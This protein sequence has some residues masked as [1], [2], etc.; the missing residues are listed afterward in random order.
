M[1]KALLKQISV[2]LEL[3]VLV[4]IDFLAIFALYSLALLVRIN[5][6]PHFHKLYQDTLPTK[7][8]TFFF[9]FLFIY[10][11]IFIFEGIYTKRI[12][13][14]REY[15]RIIKGSTLAILI[16]F[17][18]V[19]IGKL[20]PDVSRTVLILGYVFVII[21][22]PLI[23]LFLKPVIL[24]LLGLKKRIYLVAS[25]EM[26]PSI[27]RAI[28]NEPYLSFEIVGEH[29]FHEGST[30]IDQE[31]VK[32][33]QNGI[34]QTKATTLVVGLNGPLRINITGFIKSFSGHNIDILIIPDLYGIP[35]LGIEMDYF[36]N[37]Q[38]MIINIKNR[39]KN[40]FYRAI[41]RIFDLVIG[42]ILLII[43]LPLM[44][45]IAILIKTDSDGSVIYRHRRI[46]YK[47]KQFDCLKF[48]SMVEGADKMLK[49]IIE[50]NP[51]MKEEWDRFKKLPNDP[52]VTRIGR[53]LRKTSLDELPQLI[54]VIKG[55]MS[56]V[57]PRPVLYEELQ[58]FKEGS[59]YYLE[60][61]PGITGLWQISG[62][63][64]ID[65]QKRV[66][67]ESWY[68]KN[69]SLWLDITVIIRTI[70]VVFTKAGAY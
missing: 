45:V 46:G 18:I 15:E 48:R 69:Y 61:K 34:S 70:K 13:F 62:R 54:N 33:I 42:S 37:E 60:V 50:E 30:S 32:D 51:K 44:F 64:D 26:M 40:P 24:K 7:F 53:L 2:F 31:S 49:K 63:S 41:K 10:I 22:L 59:D 38:L 14:W 11:V 36:F 6:L 35:L 12:P 56:L 28:E 58:L 21:F 20:S 29:L 8:S 23:K 5:I 4:I 27:R 55:D 43:S 65:F 19:S 47:G 52:R 3:S 9:L 16:I 25:M 68:V 1:K 39:L 67:L 17:S 66:E 57:G